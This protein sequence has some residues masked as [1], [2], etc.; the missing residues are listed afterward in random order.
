[1]ALSERTFFVTGA[2]SGI[3]EFTAELLAKE[4]CSLLVHG[5]DP[6]K[7]EALVKR[8][9]LSGA[10]VRGYVADLSLMSEVRRLGEQ[11]AKEVPA[12]GSEGQ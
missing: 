1:M 7:V 8:L 10:S 3:G 11:V 5:R 4:R 6:S 2:T 9:S 12:T